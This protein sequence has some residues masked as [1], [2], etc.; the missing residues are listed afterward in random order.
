LCRPPSHVKVESHEKHEKLDIFY[1]KI[2]QPNKKQKKIMQKLGVELSQASLDNLKAAS[3]SSV[4]T[5]FSLL[6]D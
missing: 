5:S 1:P 2:H 3:A 6:R 4:S